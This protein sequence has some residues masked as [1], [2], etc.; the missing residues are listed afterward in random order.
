MRTSSSDQA[1]KRETNHHGWPAYIFLARSSF[2]LIYDRTGPEKKSEKKGERTK[3]GI[4][5]VQESITKSISCCKM[6]RRT[7]YT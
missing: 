6:L 3:L 1:E 2:E 7:Q 5:I 4:E